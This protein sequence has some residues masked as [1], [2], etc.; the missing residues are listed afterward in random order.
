MNIARKLFTGAATGALLLNLATPAFAST[1]TISGNGSDSVNTAATTTVNTNTVVQTN[2]ANVSNTVN[3]DA[4]TGFNDANGNTGGDVTVASGDAN[5]DVEVKNM[6]NANSAN[7]GCCD[8]GDTDVTISGNGSG[9]ENTAAVT[10]VNTNTLFQTNAAEVNNDVDVDANTGF[11]DANDNTGGDVLVKSGDVDT[12]VKLKTMANANV[13]NIGG[14]G[15]SMGGLS[16]MI[17]GN[18]SDSDNVI[19]LTVLNANTLDQTNAAAI[20]NEV[21]VDADTGFNDANDNT[22]G[23][24]LV[25]SGDADADVMVH[26]AVNFN[27]A[28]LDCGCLIE[29]LTAKIA[30]NG[31]ESENTIAA[32]LD[33][34][35]TAFQ[36]NLADLNND[37]DVDADTGFNDAEDNTGDVSGASDPAV[38]SGDASS[39]TD[40]HN[41]GNVN[42]LGSTDFELPEFDFDFD[43]SSMS[44]MFWAMMSIH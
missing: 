36:T 13:A 5:T 18:G 11:N 23:D 44:A 29:D 39:S 32:T 43:M 4:D 35:T 31:T 26:N 37:V 12:S 8:A 38:I 2:T 7:I 14:D 28:D 27:A 24:V 1:I 21:D 20:N 16:A 22:G 17:L 42:V 3:A 19:A 40:L 10:K 34:I 9:S 15:G 41:T 30:G 25:L 33:S 6:L